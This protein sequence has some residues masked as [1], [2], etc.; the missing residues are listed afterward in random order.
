MTRIFLPAYPPQVRDLMPA[1]DIFNVFALFGQQ[2][3]GDVTVVMPFSYRQLSKVVSNPSKE[4]LLRT[5]RQG[6]REMW[7]KLAMI[8]TNCGIEVQLDE[9]TRELRLAMHQRATAAVAMSRRGRVVRDA[10][11]A[12]GGSFDRFA[13]SAQ[14]HGHLFH[15]RTT[16]SPTAP[17]LVSPHP[18]VSLDSRAGTRL[19][20][21]AGA[22]WRWRCRC[23]CR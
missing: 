11:R 15:A 23:R 19:G 14:P 16:D 13:F 6:E 5:A 3:E 17:D 4:E 18:R 2:W 21:R 22:T 7:P 1:I 8:E 10:T 9:C 20:T 12:R